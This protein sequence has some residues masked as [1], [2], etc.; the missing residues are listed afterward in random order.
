MQSALAGSSN[1]VRDLAGKLILAQEDERKRIA[2]ELHDDV[3]Q[4]LAN[5]TTM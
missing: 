1:A 3:S 5:Y 4:Q 2:R